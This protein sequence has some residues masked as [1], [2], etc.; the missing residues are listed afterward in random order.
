MKVFRH[1][2]AGLAGCLLLAGCAHT[3]PP[4]A[5][6]NKSDVVR[7]A[8]EAAEEKGIILS[9]Y[10]APEPRYQNDG[11]WFVFFDGRGLFK[12]VG[13]HFAVRVDDQTGEARVDYGR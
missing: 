11:S 6:L 5:R 7:L 1:L 4:G 2:F 3:P 8:K 13:S 9:D 12:T 10:R